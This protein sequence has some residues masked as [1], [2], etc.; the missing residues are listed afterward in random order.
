MNH[1]NLYNNNPEYNTNWQQHGQFTNNI[2]IQKV[3]MLTQ[4]TNLHI[5]STVNDYKFNP[6]SDDYNKNWF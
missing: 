2:N 3:E 4:P 6:L 5:S 1:V